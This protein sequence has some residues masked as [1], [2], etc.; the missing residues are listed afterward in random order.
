M[1]PQS[2]ASVVR[3]V[4][5]IAAVVMGALTQ[6]LNGIHLPPAISAVLAAGGLLLLNIEHYLSDPST[7]NPVTTT[8][9]T[10][11]APVAVQAV[12]PVPVLPVVPTVPAGT[13]VHQ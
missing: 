13:M 2:I 1:T 11:A 8:T 10:T 7:G 3:Q 12:Q 5:A 4:F 9:V 6:A